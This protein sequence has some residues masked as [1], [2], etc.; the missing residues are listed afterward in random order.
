M[1]KILSQHPLLKEVFDEGLSWFVWK[2][3]GENEYPKLL[4]I[5]QAGLNAKFS[6]QQGMD[7]WQVY[8][9][10][11]AGWSVDG[12]NRLSIQR[13]IIK[14][15]PRKTLRQWWKSVG[16]LEETQICRRHWFLS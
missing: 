10:A 9:K 11:C 12:A 16:N 5:V 15:N 8:L 6:V 3:S 1:P 14:A 7:I 13:N 2:S 4:D